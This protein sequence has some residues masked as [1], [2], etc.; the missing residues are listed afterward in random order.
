MK[1]DSVFDVIPERF[2]LHRQRYWKNKMNSQNEQDCNCTS[3]IYDPTKQ[4][5]VKV[6]PTQC[7]VIKKG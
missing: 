1:L 5:Q 7:M 4:S 2:Q 3:S 6:S